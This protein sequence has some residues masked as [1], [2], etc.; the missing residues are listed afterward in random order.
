MYVFSEGNLLEIK[1]NE[2]VRL[3][4]E[5]VITKF[6]TFDEIFEIAKMEKLDYYEL[7]YSL[8]DRGFCPVSQK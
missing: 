6:L 8:L 5:G 1:V 4:N 3:C 2:L 7:L